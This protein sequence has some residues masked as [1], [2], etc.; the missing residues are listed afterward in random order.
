MNGTCE[1]EN[2]NWVCTELMIMYGLT[3]NNKYLTESGLEQVW[4]LVRW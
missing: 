1:C 4:R 3:E 2:V